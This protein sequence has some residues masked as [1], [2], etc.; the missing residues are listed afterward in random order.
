MTD[1]RIGL[2][3]YSL[4]SI[5][6]GNIEPIIQALQR[7]EFEEKLADLKGGPRPTRSPL[8]AEEED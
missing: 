8:S 4:P 3:L 5:M 7:A 2:T 1:H 6:E